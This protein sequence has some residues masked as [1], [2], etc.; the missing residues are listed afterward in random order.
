MTRFTLSSPLDMHLHLR[1]GDMLELVAPL[2]ARPFAGAVVM[3]NLVEPVNSRDKL[4]RY[5]EAIYDAIGDELFIP[6][7][8]LFFR[9]YSEAEL[10]E[11]KD[12]IIGVKL[13]P[14]GITTNSE[15]GVSNLHDIESTLTLMQEMH[16]PL[17]VHGESSGFVL[18]REKEF[19]EVYAQLAK[20][21]PQL[22]I[23]MEHITTRDAVELLDQY[24][25]LYATI[26]LHHLLITLNDVAGGLLAPHL[27]CK[28][29][30]KRPEDRDALAQ[31]ALS[32]HPKVMF[33]SDSAPHP[34]H[35][36]ECSGCAAGVF[37]APL[38][39]P[40]LTGWFEQHGALDNLQDF[41]SGNAQR[42]YKI[43][44]PEKIITLVKEPWQVP[45]KYG[46]VVPFA[47][48]QELPWRMINQ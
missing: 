41:I 47:A 12:D 10:A 35:K 45:G 5:R 19:L 25:N 31:A 23:I 39:L 21:Y 2:S 11:V 38:A 15:A 28:P 40:M 36:K 26:T 16:I 43:T 34:V 44:P 42:I 37:T 4:V 6:W 8:T 7:M 14:A 13:Y 32:G 48:G 20:A 18:D 46:N 30:A 1:E 27:F 22:T 9:N 17:L 33:G 29:I 24:E 3:P